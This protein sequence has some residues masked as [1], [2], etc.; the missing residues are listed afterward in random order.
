MR[1]KEECHNAFC[2][3]CKN[4]APYI[5]KVKK[6]S[7]SATM[8]ERMSMGS[9]G[10]DLYADIESPIKI[11]PH[12]TVIMQSNI[13]FEIPRGYFGAVYARSGLS[14][15]K[16]LRPATCVSVIDSDYRGSVGV[17]IH[18]DSNTE[19]IIEPQERVAQI[20]FQR[21][22][23]VEFELVDKLEDT[24]RGNGGFGSSGR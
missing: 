11:M 23:D 7:K 14:T 1:L 6:M 20:V 8:P 17:P 3:I 2:K 15:K 13:A 9:A 24:V 22:L 16:G 21:A 19:R 5:I 10:Y 18:N 12:E 4:Q